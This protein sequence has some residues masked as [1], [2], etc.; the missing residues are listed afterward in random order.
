MN[1]L[2]AFLSVDST[3]CDI[4]RLVIDPDH[5]MGSPP[6]EYSV[7]AENVVCAFNRSMSISNRYGGGLEVSLQGMS[8]KETFTL[9]TLP[10][11]DILT[12]DHVIIGI[13]EYNVTDVIHYTSHIESVVVKI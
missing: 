12:G 1:S 8:N 6:G 10:T 5:A 13:Q 7:I 3:T 4:L 11:V 9:I 2:P